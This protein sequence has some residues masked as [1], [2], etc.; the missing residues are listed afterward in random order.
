MLSARSGI[1]RGASKMVAEISTANYQENRLGWSQLAV[2]LH[3][4]F[5]LKEPMGTFQ[6]ECQHLSRVGQYQPH[7]AISKRRFPDPP[8]TNRAISEGF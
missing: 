2:A 4:S 6:H 7:N 8:R 1:S 5:R 3:E